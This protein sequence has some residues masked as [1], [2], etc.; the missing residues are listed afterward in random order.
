[1]VDPSER[2]VVSETILQQWREESGEFPGAERLTFGST[3]MGPGGPPIEFKLLAP[4][5]QVEQLEAAVEQCKQR[6]S[7]YPGV[8]DIRDDSS[9]GKWEYQVRVKDNA[10][11]MGV[12]AA[13]LAETV[14]A[15]YYGEEV[16]RLQRG[17]HEVKL[18]VR[19]P[20][21]QRRSLGDFEA[22]RVRTG[23]GA[24]RPLTELAEVT[25]R[26]GYSEINRVD[27]LRSI[28]V[29][30]DL[31]EDER[32]PTPRGSSTTC[33]PISCPAC[34]SIPKSASAGRA[35]ARTATNRWP[36]WPSVSYWPCSQ[37]TVC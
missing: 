37:C 11:A 13:D 30:A 34:S 35:S 18:M 3:A 36:A 10:V 9:P 25:V 8:F 4:P 6:L 14:R 32:G 21:Q 15:S 7:Q 33:R 19:Y 29:T 12:T 26:R 22:I 24:E 2:E 27:Q 20:Q 5:E 28:T 31:D 17:R 23:D 1:L 16:M